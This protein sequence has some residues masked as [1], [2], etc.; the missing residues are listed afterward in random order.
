VLIDNS[1]CQ[2]EWKIFTRLIVILF[3]NRP[4]S[5]MKKALN[6]EDK[7]VYTNTIHFFKRDVCFCKTNGE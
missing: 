6:N 4:K 1:F 5:I 2:E 7:V 3:K